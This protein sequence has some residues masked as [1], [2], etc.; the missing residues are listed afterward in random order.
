MSNVF[1]QALSNTLQHEK[2]YVN[3]PA[4]PGGETR[5]GISKRA[6]PDID[7]KTLTLAEARE[8]YRV[9]YW[10]KPRFH[11]VPQ[12]ALAVKLF[13]LGV[14]CGPGTATKMLQRAVN[15]VCA[16]EVAPQ[17]RAP[18]RQSVAR[19]LGGGVLRIDGQLGPV[20]LQVLATCP[21]DQ[22][23]LAALKGEAYLH[24]RDLNP[25]YIPGWLE[26][27]EA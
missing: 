24:Y 22:A 5:Y 13:D 15:V 9:H 21:Y 10:K 25:L 16:G 3:D 2:G 8:I 12:A 18:W 1:E 17:R 27:L 19:I 6:F 23:L 20:T 14:N 7:I 11:Q 26:R 4:D